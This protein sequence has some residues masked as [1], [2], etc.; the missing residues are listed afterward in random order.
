MDRTEIERRLRLV[1]LFS[2]MT[3]AAISAIAALTAPT[4]FDAGAVLI[5]EGTPGDA[6]LVLV[7]GTADVT[8]EG[9][10][11][12]SLGSGHFVGEISLID[13]KPRTATVTATSPVTA[14]VLHRDGFLELIDRFPSVR[15]GVLMALTERI[16]SDA[17]RATD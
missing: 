16:R 5:A 17:K 6:F 9:A 12:R 1:P 3:D 7:S 8:R 10:L 4:D 13:G 15:L 14:L 2:A 11:L